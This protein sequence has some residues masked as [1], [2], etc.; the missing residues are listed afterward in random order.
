MECSTRASLLGNP[1]TAA[2]GAPTVT[3][4]GSELVILAYG[5]AEEQTFIRPCASIVNTADCFAIASDPEEGDLTPFLELAQ[6]KLKRRAKKSTHAHASGVVRR[7]LSQASR[8]RK[9]PDSNEWN[10]RKVGLGFTFA[11]SLTEQVEEAS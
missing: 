8:N 3:L 7:F 11:E 1:A 6:V 5:V 9:R 4:L 10:R 2:A